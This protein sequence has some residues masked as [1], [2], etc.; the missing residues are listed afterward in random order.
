MKTGQYNPIRKVHYKKM[1]GKYEYGILS[2]SRNP[3]LFLYA[4]IRPPYP[5]RDAF[6]YLSFIRIRYGC[7]MGTLHGSHSVSRQ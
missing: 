6:F 4:K 7:S 3:I 2:Y 5:D 1:A